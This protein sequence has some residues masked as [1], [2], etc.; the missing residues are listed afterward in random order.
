MSGPNHSN[1]TSLGRG[2]PG[3]W[4]HRPSRRTL[5]FRIRWLPKAKLWG[6]MYEP[7]CL[8][9]FIGDGDHFDCRVD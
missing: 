5:K 6:D 1:I 9:K 4:N 7:I 2:A 3:G 8:D